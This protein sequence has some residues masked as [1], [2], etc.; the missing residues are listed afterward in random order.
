MNDPIYG[1]AWGEFAVTPNLP[2]DSFGVQMGVKNLAVEG[3]DRARVLSLNEGLDRPHMV[4]GN[5]QIE[6][7]GVDIG[8]FSPPITV[9]VP[10]L[11]PK[12]YK[13]YT[14][15][16][17]LVGPAP[18]SKTWVPLEEAERETST[19]V[20]AQNAERK[21]SFKVGP[22]AGR[23]GIVFEITKWPVDDIIISWEG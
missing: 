14:R 8:V 5:I 16:F 10:Y 1:D 4:I 17:F 23:K 6:L 9:E 2:R 3:A 13:G 18:E 22:F 7:N 15:L 20:R 12:E 19:F 21:Y 11:D